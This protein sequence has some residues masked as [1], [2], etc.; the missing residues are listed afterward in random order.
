M[1]QTNLVLLILSI[2]VI[3]YIFNYDLGLSEQ[4]G[5]SLPIVKKS[6]PHYL[7]H[8]RELDNVNN[9]L[10]R[11]ILPADTVTNELQA[12]NLWDGRSQLEYIEPVEKELI[13]NDYGQDVVSNDVKTLVEAK[14]HYFLDQADIIDY[15]GKKYYWDWRYPREPLPI[16]FAEN[17]EKWVKENPNLYPSYVI[18]S[19]NYSK[20]KPNDH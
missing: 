7:R 16:E 18:S 14:Q 1:N 20:L 15:Y 12:Y 5:G 13:F 10:N 11:P 6:K 4:F 3:W 17:A 8:Y 19:R 9:V 2:G